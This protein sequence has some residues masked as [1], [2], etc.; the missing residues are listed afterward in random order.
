M[1]DPTP[2][3]LSLAEAKKNLSD[4]VSFFGMTTGALVAKVQQGVHTDADEQLQKK[5]M[6]SLARALDGFDAA[7]MRE[8]KGN[9]ALTDEVASEA[10]LQISF[11]I[12]STVHRK[13]GG[14]HDG[15][16][17]VLDMEV[18]VDDDDESPDEV[19]DQP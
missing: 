9:E 19:E 17:L 10:R 2:T 13:C 11:A 3:P 8:G 15:L 4:A 12:A 14:Y 7:A 5:V 1:S 16:E 6:L 18:Q